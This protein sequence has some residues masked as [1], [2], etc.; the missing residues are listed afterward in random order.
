[1]ASQFTKKLQNGPHLFPPILPWGYGRVTLWSFLFFLS[2][3]LIQNSFF[4]SFSVSE[5]ESNK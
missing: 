3:I 4:F 1:M 2:I 5:L